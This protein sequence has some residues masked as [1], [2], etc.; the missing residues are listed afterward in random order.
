MAPSTLSHRSL[1]IEGEKV[2][3]EGYEPR[4][5]FLFSG[6]LR[7]LGSI[8][9]PKVSPWISETTKN[10][11]RTVQRHDG[12]MIFGNLYASVKKLVR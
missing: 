5:R 9:H 11:S 8:F 1:E 4:S 7:D 2:L 3:Q 12:E 6:S 10:N